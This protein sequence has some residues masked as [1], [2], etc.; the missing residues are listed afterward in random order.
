[1]RIFREYEFLVDL[2]KSERFFFNTDNASTAAI[3]EVKLTMSEAPPSPPPL[4][5]LTRETSDGEIR[6]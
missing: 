4:A 3:T 5:V 1:M 2:W 6:K